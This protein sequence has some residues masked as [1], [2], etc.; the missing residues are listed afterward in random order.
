MMK[1]LHL[2]IAS[3][4]IIVAVSILATRYLNNPKTTSPR[5]NLWA[6]TAPP[7][8]LNLA[9]LMETDGLG[10]ITVEPFEIKPNGE[11]S[12]LEIPAR[13]TVTNVTIVSE[14]GDVVFRED[15]MCCESQFL[16]LNTLKKGNYRVSM[17]SCHVG[18]DFQFTIIE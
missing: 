18:G 1:A 8:T 9:T 12:I 6:K 11:G 5:P 17:A 15:W 10:E 14:K 7:D 13:G 2:G 3:I 16:D 4:A